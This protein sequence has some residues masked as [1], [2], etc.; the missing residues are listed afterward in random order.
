M[1]FDDSR[2][3][4]H[5]AIV[6]WNAITTPD[7]DQ[8]GRPKYALKVV[9]NPNNPELAEFDQIANKTLVESEFKGTL[10]HG[11]R[12]P[13]GVA[14]PDE[15]NGLYTGWTV[16]NCN[17]KRLPAV[18]DES[19]NVLDPMQYG[20]QI[21]GGQVVDV[22]VHCYAYNAK[23]NKGV[24]TGLDAFAIVASAQAAPISFGGSGIATAGAFGGPRPQQA[25]GGFN[26][27]AQQ[28]AQGGYNPQAQQQA[29]GGF[30]PQAQQ[31]AQGGQQYPQQATDFL[32]QQ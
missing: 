24:A 5:G 3:K 16:L 19:G 32:P 1:F 17:T 14:G 27:Q 6:V 30:N 13:R 12:M 29:Q 28:Q 9:V 31:P 21:Y 8:E 20:P 23:G 15:F 18:Y 10:P 25:Q 4:I 2:V 11:G 26:P 22:L 7:Q